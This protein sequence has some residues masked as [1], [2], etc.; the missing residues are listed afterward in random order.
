MDTTVG[1]RI[2]AAR[3]ASKLSQHDLAA[4]LG[5]HATTISK[6]ERDEMAPR[7]AVIVSLATECGVHFE[8]LALGT[9]P[10]RARKAA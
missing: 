7:V 10:R 6:W 2:A 1:E 3:R 5:T 8:W 9:G 4:R